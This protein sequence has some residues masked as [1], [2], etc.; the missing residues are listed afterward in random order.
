MFEYNYQNNPLCVQAKVLLEGTDRHTYGSFD[1][2]LRFLCDNFT[3]GQDVDWDLRYRNLYDCYQTEIE[4]TMT[5][6]TEQGLNLFRLVEPR[7][8][9]EIEYVSWPASNY[10]YMDPS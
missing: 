10:D 1:P 9:H 8:E 7:L 2:C 4:L 3:Q 6:K 5:F